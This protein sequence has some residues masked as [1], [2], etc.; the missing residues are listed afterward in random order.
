VSRTHTSWAT[1][2]A[3]ETQALAEA[4]GRAA[5][6]GDVL[7]LEGP[8]G[9]GKTCFAQG[10]ARGL[11]VKTPVKS[12]TF[13]LVTQHKGRVPLTHVDLCR[14]EGANSLDDLGLEERGEASVLAV[15][16]GE[17]LASQLADGLV[18]ALAEAGNDR[19]CLT[20][21]ALGPRGG[22][23]LAAWVQAVQEPVSR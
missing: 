3:A 6:P 22:E 9:A 20:V 8:L 10:L 7:L 5:R 2:S 23:W 15:E 16:W 19:R 11:G 12:P 17:K 21:T 1:N 4:L 13:V 14:I 18:V